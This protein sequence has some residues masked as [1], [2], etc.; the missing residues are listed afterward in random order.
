MARYTVNIYDQEYDIRVEYR[1]ERYVVTVNGEELEIT[2]K[3][4]WGNRSLLL[5]DNESVEVDVRQNGHDTEKIVFMYGKEIPT[6]IEDY[7]LAQLRK[8]AG[9]AAGGAAETKL[10]APMPG[11]VVGFKVAVGDTV[12][13]N[14]PLLVIEA[15]KMENV[16]KAKTDGVVKEI[17]VKTGQSVEKGETLIEFE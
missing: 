4:L 6:R 12:K 10:H 9:L 8:T 13:K 2:R 17:P 3:N 7:N 16:L 5:V 14:Q 11:L 15:M 1:S